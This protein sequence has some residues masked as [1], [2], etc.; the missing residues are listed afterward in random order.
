M[1]AAQNYKQVQKV[2]LIIL[3]ANFGV[4]ILKIVVGTLIRSSS[5]TA[6]GFH[7]LSDGTSNIIAL[8]GIHFAAKPADKGHPYGHRKLETLTGMAIGV[9]L[10][11]VGIKVVV[12]AIGK[13]SNPVMPSITLFSLIA[14]V[15][16]LGI[17][18]FVTTY[19]RRMGEKL[20][21]AVLI[22]DAT[23]T[24]SDIYITIGVLLTLV[25][26]KLGLPAILDPIVSMV[27]A[28]FIF[29]A[30]WG[31]LKENGN[32]LMD[33]SPIE[34]DKVRDA[35]LPLAGV[36]DVHKIRSRGTS[37]QAFLDMHVLVDPEM[38]VEASHDLEHKIEET[39]RTTLNPN[40]QVLVH[41]EPYQ[42]G[43][44]QTETI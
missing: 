35:I 42:E 22:S 25:G 23:H 33:A 41:I 44:D 4:A 26:V 3:F 1:D 17:N 21:S 10:L 13:F 32:V 20:G 36:K 11:F 7:S 19:E 39:V 40:T 9:L 37:Q 27:V 31:V 29:Y 43:V 5:M 30:A 18:I 6:D 28:G 24:K 34:T 15:I 14:L 12:E 2:L 38:S 16:T 8:I